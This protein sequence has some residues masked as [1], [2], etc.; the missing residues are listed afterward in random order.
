MLG[1]AALEDAEGAVVPGVDD[2]GLAEHALDAAA[3]VL[4]APECV[5]VDLGHGGPRARHAVA[6]HRDG[7]LVGVHDERHRPCGVAWRMDDADAALDLVA[8]PNLAQVG[9]ASSIAVVQRGVA[10]SLGCGLRAYLRSH[11]W[12]RTSAWGKTS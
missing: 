1:G 2:F 4:L 12:M 9:I 6:G 8:V 10:Q 3:R 5:G 7:P 11:S